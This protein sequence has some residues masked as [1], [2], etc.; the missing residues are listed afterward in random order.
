[1]EENYL[2]FVFATY[3]SER[4]DDSKKEC[5]M[6][7][8][9]ESS[10][11]DQMHVVEL[12]LQDQEFFPKLMD[13]FRICEDLE[14]VEGLQMIFKLVKGICQCFHFSLHILLNSPQIFD[15]IFGEEFIMDVIG[16]LELYGMLF[17]SKSIWNVSKHLDLR[18]SRMLASGLYVGHGMLLPFG[19]EGIRVGIF[20]LP[21]RKP[22]TS[23]YPPLVLKFVL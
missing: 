18:S 5:T 2:T 7:T 6:Q 17:P 1:M 10:V 14:N 20:G 15:K 11:A 21:I 8:V 9:V 19:G 4:F 22:G 3:S 23:K 12:I 16:S 13:L